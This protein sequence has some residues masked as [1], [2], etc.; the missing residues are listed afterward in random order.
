MQGGMGSSV[1]VEFFPLSSSTRFP[2]AVISIL[3]AYFCPMLPSRT[4]FSCLLRGSGNM[5]CGGEGNQQHLARLTSYTTA[6]NELAETGLEF[7]VGK[8]SG[9]LTK[10]CTCLKRVCRLHAPQNGNTQPVVCC[11]RQRH[12][13]HVSRRCSVSGKNEQPQGEARRNTALSE[14]PC[15][16]VPMPCISARLGRQQG[17]SCEVRLSACGHDISVDVAQDDISPDSKQARP[18]LL[19]QNERVGRSLPR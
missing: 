7:P 12:L 15:A 11:S 17:P 2:Y 1:G 14:R 18:I 13:R 3:S 19:R 10:S 6:P 8:A 5:D 16:A 9:T 4:I